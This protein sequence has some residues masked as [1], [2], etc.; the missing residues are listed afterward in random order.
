MKFTIPTILT[1][2]RI[3][4]IPVLVLVFYLPQ[5]WTHPW[6]NFAA[7]FVFVLGALTDWAD[8]WIARRWNL[9]SAFGAFLD[10]VADKLAVTVALLLIVEIQPTQL[11]TSLAAIIIGREIA[12][13]ALREWM[14]EVGHGRKV[15]VAWLGKL[16]TIVQMVAI[17][18]LLYQQDIAHLPTF[19]IGE[20]LL[21]VAAAL[22]LIS[23]YGYVRAAWPS[24]RGD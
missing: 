10:P 16:K 22:T 5:S 6:T 3:L 7:T 18:L 24:L 2:F 19:Q 4:L 12:I 14:A 11:M 20:V 13:S 8:G 1:L 15:K 17:S 9:I 23:G 21:G